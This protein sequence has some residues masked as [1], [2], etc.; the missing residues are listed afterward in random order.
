MIPVKHLDYALSQLNYALSQ[1]PGPSE[2]GAEEI[3]IAAP[4]RLTFTP[5][6]IGA[7]CNE[8]VPAFVFK[9]TEHDGWVL[10]SWPR[11]E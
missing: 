7:P 2:W 4:P 1:P 9:K 6:N 11:Y 5:E 3:K 10:V 8:P